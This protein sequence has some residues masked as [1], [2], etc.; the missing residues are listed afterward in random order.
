MDYTKEIL[1][2]YFET[3]WRQAGLKWTSE[4]QAEIEAAVDDLVCG[5]KAEIERELKRELK[6]AV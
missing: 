5:I 1:A 3:V 4:N 6:R 2:H